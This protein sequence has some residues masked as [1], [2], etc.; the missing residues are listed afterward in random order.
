MKVRH[1]NI[2]WLVGYC[3]NV[4]HTHEKFC[5]EIVLAENV[6]R[7]LCLEYLPEGSLDTFLSGK[8]L[9]LLQGGSYY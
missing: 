4:R 5:Q 7:V 9:F 3:Y 2:V 1:Q 6:D 8:I